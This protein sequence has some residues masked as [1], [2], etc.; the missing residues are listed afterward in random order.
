VKLIKI[1]LDSF[2]SYDGTGLFAG[3]SRYA[4]LEGRVHLAAVQAR[5]L[6]EWWALLLRKMM[7]PTPRDELAAEVMRLL[8]H[9]EAQDVLRVLSQE[10]PAIIMLARALHDEAK[11]TEKGERS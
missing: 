11:H 2:N 6:F 3:P 8:Q 9:H 4:V 10:T 7:W 5:S 1:S